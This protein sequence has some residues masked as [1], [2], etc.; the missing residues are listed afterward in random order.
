ME[1]T[2]DVEREVIDVGIG[3]CCSTG[4][5]SDLPGEGC[6]DSASA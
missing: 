2:F 4:A 5:D 6:G 3:E 1:A